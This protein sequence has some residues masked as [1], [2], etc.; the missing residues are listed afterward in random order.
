MKR[1]ISISLGNT[2]LGKIPQFNL[3]PKLSCQ[4]SKYCSGV[5]EGRKFECYAIKAWRQYADTRK[6]WTKNIKLCH[7]RLSLVEDELRQYFDRSRPKWFRIHSAGDFFSQEYLDM[8]LRLATTYQD[9]KFLAFTKAYGLN[10]SRAP[11]NLKVVYSVMPET[12]L[13]DVPVGSRAYAGP[14]PQLV[15]GR[16]FS[17]P[18]TCEGCGV[19]W[20]LRDYEHVHF[21]L[22]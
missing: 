13:A 18:G 6:A 20:N 4:N 2:K 16:L 1:H 11:K 3:A 9:I 22:H 5:F 7:T 17:C 15:S 14:V 19:C 10:F 12:P 21:D 8:W